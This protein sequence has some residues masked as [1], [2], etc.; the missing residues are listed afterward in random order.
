MRVHAK[1]Y[2]CFFK[3]QLIGALGY[4]SNVRALTGGGDWDPKKVLYEWLDDP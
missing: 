4:V 1:E 3:F 2:Q